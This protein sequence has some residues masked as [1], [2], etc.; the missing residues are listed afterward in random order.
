[1]PYLLDTNILVEFLLDQEKADDVELFFKKIPPQN[2]F[3]SIFSL[4]SI[5]IILFRHKKT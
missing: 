2:C 4:F 3:I 5:G 1:M